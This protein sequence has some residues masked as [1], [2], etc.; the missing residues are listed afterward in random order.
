MKETN[1]LASLLLLIEQF[2]ITI[3][4]INGPP[5]AGKE[6]KGKLLYC[7]LKPILAYHN[8]IRIET[9]GEI[10]RH[11]ARNT[12]LGKK[13]KAANRA[14]RAKGV[15]FPDELIFELLDIAI[16]R[17]LDSARR[18]GDKRPLLILL[19]GFPRTMAQGVGFIYETWFSLACFDLPLYKCIERIRLRAKQR[20]RL[21]L[22]PRKDDKPSVVM[23]RYNNEYMG[24]TMP[25]I[26][27]LERQR[28]G[29]ATR[30]KADDGVYDQLIA[31]LR[32]LRGFAG[33]D[34]WITAAN[35]LNSASNSVAH[36][37]AKIDGTILP[38][39]KPTIIWKIEPKLDAH[40]VPTQTYGSKAR[41]PLCAQG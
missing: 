40:T 7:L 30:I 39:P 9:S 17:K 8:V 37:V 32:H 33:F 19:D 16:R 35:I 5:G 25:V 23:R 26:D 28:P 15:L 11:I 10:D 12:P 41:Q 2:K 21:G 34:N 22:K 13:L 4:S 36:Q 38:R 31:L 29:G 6:F 3:L 18:R 24:K 27:E 14:L 20:K 1:W